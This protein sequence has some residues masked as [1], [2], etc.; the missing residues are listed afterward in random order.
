MKYIIKIFIILFI[1]L[2]F[3]SNINPTNASVFNI[4][5][6]IQYCQWSDCWL[7]QWIK[8]ID[9]IKDIEKGKKASVYIQEIIVKILN[10]V[11]LVWVIYIIYA[12]INL[13][14]WGWD[15]EKTK[16]S[17]QI[18]MYVIIWIIIIFLAGPILKFVIGILN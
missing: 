10:Y 4:K 5:D 18:I 8:A 14:I 12:W 13:L 16:K 11:A 1:L 3:F 17:K 2:W 15:E 6:K 7:K 9:G